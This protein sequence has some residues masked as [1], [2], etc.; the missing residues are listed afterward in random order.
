MEQDAEGRGGM[1]RNMRMMVMGRGKEKQV[2]ACGL[3]V[4]PWRLRCLTELPKQLAPQSQIFFK[5]CSNA[6]KMLLTHTRFFPY[7]SNIVPGSVLKELEEPKLSEATLRC[8]RGR[9]VMDGDERGQRG[10]EVGR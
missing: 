10:E 7:V 5:I 3:S 9:W 8:V 4:T 1:K 2:V 6:S